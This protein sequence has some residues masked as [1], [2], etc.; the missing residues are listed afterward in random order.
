MIY[1][2]DGGQDVSYD[3]GTRW[4]SIRLMGGALSYHVSADMRR[5]YWVCTGLQDNGSWCGPSYT[6]TGG[7]HQWNWI[8]VGG[9]DGFQTQVDPT[10]PNV[11]YTESQNGSIN[12]YDLNTGTT[13]NI[14]PAYTPTVTR[15]PRAGRWR[16]RRTRWWCWW[17]RWRWRRRWWPGGRPL[18]TSSTTVPADSLNQFNW[19]S[20]IRLSPHNPSTVMFGG[21]QLFISRD[22]GDTWTMTTSLG[23]NIDINDRSILEQQYSLPGCGR[24]GE[25]GKPCI[26]SRHDGYVANEFGTITE[27]AESPVL[28]GVLWAGTDDGNVQVSRDG[29]NTWTE[30]GKNIPN[31]NHEYYVSGVEAS[32]Y[33]AGTAYVSLDGH[34]Q[35]DMKPYVFKTTDYG[36]TWTAVS[37]N[38]PQ[39]G[40]VNSIRQD[41]V[42]RN[43]LYAP[44]EFGFF[45]SLNDGQTW[46]KFMPN[47]PDVRVDEVLVHPRDN[48]LILAT[49]ARGIWIMDDI[50]ALQA[51]T[52][53]LAGDTILFKP[54]DAV[55]LESRP[56]EPDVG[57]RRQVVGRRSR[58]ARHG[59]RLL[60]E[61][62]AVRRSA[63]DDHQYRDGRGRP[64]VQGAA[65]PSR[66][67][68]LPVGT[69]G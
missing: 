3:A 40:C 14:K 24:G 17:R 46:T 6:R 29:G 13:T 47:L 37:G 35:D 44:T 50:T 33:D 16:R 36:Q 22:R 8:S 12:R 27:L 49:H 39:W 52:D 57:S 56:Q 23:K 4:E 51:M 15:R 65:G 21:R 28:P 20:P 43:L 66:T 68:S 69:D 59:D 19:N 38:L 63:R 18:A 64:D 26:L 1:G 31:V 10:D 7:I 5:P 53:Q 41:P 9:G 25:R 32:W 67:Q 54:R 60:L 2:N 11:F 48:D 45:I 42:N 61:V 58:A 34:R 62:G 55:H 30:V